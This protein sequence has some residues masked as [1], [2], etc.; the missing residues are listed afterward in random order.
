MTIEEIPKI[1]VSAC[2]LGQEVRYDGGHKHNRYVTRVLGQ[3]LELIPW[4]PEM[5]IGL[6]VPRP[7]IH[8]ESRHGETRAVHVDDASQD[9]TDRLIAYA[10]NLAHGAAALSGYIFKKDSPSCGVERVRVYTG[11]GVERNG[12][13][14]YARE[15][16]AMVP[17]LPVEEEGRLNDPVLRDNF[18]TRVFTLYRWQQQIAEGLTPGSLVAFHT[19]H[20]F[21]LLAHHEPGYRELGRLVAGAGTEDIEPL[22]SRY[23]TLL[24]QTLKHHATP[25]S[26]ANVLMHIMGFFKER[27]APDDK[28]ELLEIIDTYRLGLVPVIVPIALLN[29]YLRKYPDVYIEKQVYLDPH[30]RELMLRNHV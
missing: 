4:C 30:P 27:L 17:H 5:G 25:K 1:G 11:N 24:M 21:L 10:R 29:H 14:I 22:A 12:T 7:P 23:L 28:V 19:K 16:M 18:I 3:H 2:L 13:G 9:V 26:H 8:L 15:I 20:K 6:G